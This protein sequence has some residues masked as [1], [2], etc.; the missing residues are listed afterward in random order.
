MSIPSA[1]CAVQIGVMVSS[2]ARVSFHRLPAIDPESS[3]SITV[4]KLERN[5]YG[6]SEPSFDPATI[7]ALGSGAAFGAG[8][9]AG[10]A[11]AWFLKGFPLDAGSARIVSAGRG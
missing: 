5:A 11:S 1:S 6:S 3:T 10:G 2:A 9:Y 4:S 8:E 7:C